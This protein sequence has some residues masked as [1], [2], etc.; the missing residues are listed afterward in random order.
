MNDAADLGNVKASVI[1]ASTIE[2]N[3]GVKNHYVIGY[4]S[5]DGDL[6]V[7]SKQLTYKERQA[8]MADTLGI[9]PLTSNNWAFCQWSFTMGAWTEVLAGDGEMEQKLRLHMVNNPPKR[10]R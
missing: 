4:C 5:A 3:R 8:Y 1:E 10:P 9:D 6:V 2:S 7:E